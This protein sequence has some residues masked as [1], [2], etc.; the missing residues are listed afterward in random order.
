[1]K[2]IW[3]SLASPKLMLVLLGFIIISCMI[4]ALIP[5]NA[6]EAFYRE[7]YGGLRAE[8][9]QKLGLVDIFGGL[10]FRLLLLLVAVNLVCCAVRR[11]VRSWSDRGLACVHL[12]IVVILLGALINSLWHV[13]GYLQL[14]EGQSS[15]TFIR[16]DKPDTEGALPVTVKLV[17]FFLDRD[18]ARPVL[19]FHGMPPA[20]PTLTFE[21]G[22]LRDI[23]S[24]VELTGKDG[25]PRRA[26]IRV[27][28]PL[29]YGGWSFYQW[30]YVRELPG[31]TI[32]MV[33]RDRGLWVIY[34]GFGVLLVGAWF[35]A[36]LGPFLKPDSQ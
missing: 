32:L 22:A 7:T 4:G 10:A 34:F 12:G 28:Q 5:Q 21:E 23:Y 36:Y 24:R 20:S 17:D 30:D 29:E 19:V 35:A 14:S 13:G 27:N 33:S 8:I 2:Q 11:G 26:D 18:P 16:A 25:R 1:M 31:T 9:M 3:K 6:P 15:S